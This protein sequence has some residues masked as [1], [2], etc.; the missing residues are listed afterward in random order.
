MKRY[1]RSAV[2]DVTSEEY[3]DKMEMAESAETSSYVL[4]QLA[5]DDNRF[6]RKAVAENKNTPAEV[7]KLLVADTYAG[8]RESVARN[9]N[10]TAEVLSCLVSDYSEIIRNAIVL[11]PNVT[12][13]IL[14]ELLKN[15]NKDNDNAFMVARCEKASPTILTYIFEHVDSDDYSVMRRLARNPNTPIEILRALSEF[16]TEYVS[17]PAKNH[18]EKLK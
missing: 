9:P 6:I 18:L 7:L 16:P 17:I 3:G 8:V 12:D 14:M 11:S 2:A 4:K 5:T 1:I 10:A 13:K 15:D